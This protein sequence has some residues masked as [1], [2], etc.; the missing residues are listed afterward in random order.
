MQNNNQLTDEEIKQR[1]EEVFSI[2]QSRC[3]DEQMDLLRRSFQL[4]FEAHREQK[5]KSG[6]PYIIHPIA[7][8]RIVADELKLGAEPVCAAFLHDVVEDT[9][10]TD[11]DIRRMFGDDVAFLVRVVT[12]QK[13]KNYDMSKQL[14]N[15]KQ[16][17]DSMHYDVRAILIKLADRLHNMR[18]LESMLPAKQMK[19]A[20]ETD[21]FFA[22]LANRLGLYTAKIELENLS[23]RYRCPKIYKEISQKIEHD[24]QLDKIRMNSFSEKICKLLDEHGIK[25]R[26]EVAYRAPYSLYRKMVQKNQDYEHLENRHFTRIVF[27]EKIS[28]SEK[29]MC[30]RIYSLLTSFFRERPKSFLNYIDQPKQNGYQ[31]FH[32]QLLSDYGMWEEV[33]ISSERMIRVSRLGCVAEGKGSKDITAWLENFR[34]VLKDVARN[35]QE[36]VGGA[37]FFIE[38]VRASF[39]NDDIQVYTP[40]GESMRLP[41]NSTAL[42]FAFNIHSEVGLHAKYAKVNGRLASVKTVLHRGDCVE[43]GTDP[44]VWPTEDW[45]M[46]AKSYKALRRINQYLDKVP[47]PTYNRCLRCHPIPGEE[48][49]GFKEADGRVTVHRRDCP[50]AISVASQLGDSIVAVDYSADDNVLYPARIT[51]YA[52][53]RQHLLSDIIESISNKFHLSISSL[54][55]VTTDQI[56]KCQVDFVVHSYEELNTIVSNVAA[57][58]AV[59][60]VKYENE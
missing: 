45:R 28:M 16:M 35:S 6:E 7:V 20:G 34:N 38:S 31:S 59:D 12:K 13:K 33:H 18:T 30:L 56:V 42:D 19:I 10:Y 39:Y 50:D 57:I 60:E 26:H 53:D 29:N 36:N 21:Y 1:A 49:I 2:M 5:R 24:K 44:D 23:F 58:E 40:G 4:A 9:P 32:V 14:D 51:V 43:V 41:K 15:F 27:P 46:S 48:V 52:V 55:T 8:A 37:N 22:P 3:N 25:Y 47:Q 17:L 54:H 11:D